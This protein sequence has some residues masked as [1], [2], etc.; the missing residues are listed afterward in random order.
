MYIPKFNKIFCQGGRSSTSTA[1]KKL[2][3]TQGNGNEYTQKQHQHYVDGMVNVRMLTYLKILYY[4]SS[5][6]IQYVH[7]QVMGNQMNFV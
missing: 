1:A 6:Y 4:F 7:V 3:H 5:S 2:K